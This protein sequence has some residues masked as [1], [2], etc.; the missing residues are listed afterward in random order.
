MKEDQLLD[1]YR[2]IWN[3]R[4]LASGPHPADT[5]KEAIKRDLLDE[6]THPRVRKPLEEKHRISAARIAAASIGAVEKELLLEEYT[7][8]LK[9]LKQE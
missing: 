3:N 4:E 8:M 7:R 5:L 6:G 1:A 9:A 2:Q